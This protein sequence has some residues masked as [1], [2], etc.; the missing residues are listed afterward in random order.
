MVERQ[1]SLL[2]ARGLTDDRDRLLTAD[3]A[4]AELHEACGGTLPG[5]LAVPELLDLVQQ[6]RRLGLRIAREFSAFDGDDFVSGFVRVHP[7]AEAHGGGCE[8]LVENWQ[9]APAPET[10]TREIAERLDEID[11]TAAEVTGRLDPRQRIQLLSAGAA[12]TFDLQSA[13]DATPGSLWTDLV[14][15][16]DLAHKQPMHWRLLDGAACT[17]PGSERK[18]RVRLLPLG[19]ANGAPRGFE[20][21]LVADRPLSEDPAEKAAKE[22]AE[23]AHARLI[24]GALT[25]V[26]R[27]PI[28]RIIANAETIRARL[29]GPLRAEY[30]EYAGNIASAGQH[31][32]GMLEDLAELEVVEAPGFVT[33]SEPVDLAD[34]ARRA[35]GIL[36]V[37]AQAKTIAINLPPKGEDHIATAEF[38]RVLQI[39]INLIGN[40]IAYSPENST[41]T[42]RA[43]LGPKPQTVALTVCDEGPGIAPDQ[44]AQ[45]FDKFER[46]G[47]DSEDG[48][49]LG[50][51]ISHRLA[52]V[53][54]GDLDLVGS[55]TSGAAFRLTLPAHFPDN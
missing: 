23:A 54:G 17:I 15:L 45:L 31:L 42:V 11:R 3:D 52:T 47:R 48:S 7:L 28:A 12:D 39:L 50:L 1:P 35:A 24:G 14:T 29:A 49:G 38:R 2:A 41:V 33:Q 30:S 16:R 10:N 46:L 18:W 36:G 34:A 53:M 26:L 25:P 21:L 20:L 55:N 6:G 8:L 51:Y 44:Q 43:G 40:A 13:S 27:Q 9:R 4:L 5:I 22:V 37:R 19:P 32:T